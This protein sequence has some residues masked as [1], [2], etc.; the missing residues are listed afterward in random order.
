MLHLIPFKDFFAVLVHRFSTRIEQ[1]L[2]PLRDRNLIRM[3]PQILPY[4]LHDLQLFAQRKL[5]NFSDAHGLESAL[6]RRRSKRRGLGDTGISAARRVL[7]K[8]PTLIEFGGIE[9]QNGRK[10]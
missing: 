9:S 7:K 1:V 8:C 4:C 6:F 10:L 3:E 2:V 5:L